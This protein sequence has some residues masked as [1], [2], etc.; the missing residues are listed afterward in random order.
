MS[1]QMTWTTGLSMMLGW[2][3]KLELNNASGWGQCTWRF[4]RFTF[5]LEDVTLDPDPNAFE[6][7]T[8]VLK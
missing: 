5:R 4:E 7:N 3:F 2:I 8:V 6:D 1:A